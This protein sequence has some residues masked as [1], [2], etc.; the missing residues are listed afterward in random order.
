[1][2]YGEKMKKWCKLSLVKCLRVFG[3]K[4]WQSFAGKE[5]NGIFEGSFRFYR[6]GQL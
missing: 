2:D 1:M 4:I 3:T 5:R 6:R